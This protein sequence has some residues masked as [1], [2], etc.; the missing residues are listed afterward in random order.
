MQHKA[1][2]EDD[3]GVASLAARRPECVE[4][5]TIELTAIISTGMFDER[6][7]GR[8]LIASII[9]RIYASLILLWGNCRNILVGR[10]AIS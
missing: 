6:G 10:L 3:G 5:A 8:L 7:F 2:I 1:W 4:N 9:L